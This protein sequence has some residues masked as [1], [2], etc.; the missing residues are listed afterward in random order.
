MYITL[1]RFIT[2]C[3]DVHKN[4][5][6]SNCEILTFCCE[7]HK[8]NA[9][10]VSFDKQNLT[11]VLLYYYCWAKLVRCSAKPH[12]L[13]FPPTR[14]I[15]SIIH[16]YPCKIL[17]IPSSIIYFLFL[18]SDQICL[19]PDQMRW[20][21]THISFSLRNQTYRYINYFRIFT[22]KLQ[23]TLSIGPALAQKWL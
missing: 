5:V 6:S 14:L 22:C 15:N 4:V 17:C 19:L 11:F 3:I 7:N 13:S 18:L 1:V 23:K 8:I 21:L 9:I 16:E 12:I 20:K 10:F 2:L